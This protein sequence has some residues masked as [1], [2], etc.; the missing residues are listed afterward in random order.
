MTNSASHKKGKKTDNPLFRSYLN[1][2][3]EWDWVLVGRNLFYLSLFFSDI[4]FPDLKEDCLN[5][6]TL[7]S[8]ESYNAVQERLLSDDAAQAFEMPLTYIKADGS[9]YSHFT[10]VKMLAVDGF[11]EMVLMGRASHAK[12]VKT[13]TVE[14]SERY[15][16]LFN[17]IRDAVLVSEVLPD[18]TPGRFI[19]VNDVACKQLGYS[20]EE[21]LRLSLAHIVD[22]KTPR[23]ESFSLMKRLQKEGEMVFKGSHT[24]KTGVK[25]PVEIF[26]KLHLLGDSPVCI[27]IARDLNEYNAQQD[28]LEESRIRFEVFM[29]HLPAI[30]SIRDEDSRFTYVNPSF[31]KHFGEQIVGKTLRDVFPPHVVNA[32]EQSA[33]EVFKYGVTTKEFKMPDRSGHLRTWFMYSFKLPRY[34]SSP[35][36][37]CVGIDISEQK[38]IEA[39][40][41]RA[42]EHAEQMYRLKTSLLTNLSH[43]V[44][45]PMNGIIGFS[46]IMLESTAEPDLQRQASLIFHSAVRLMKT[47]DSMLTLSTLESGTYEYKPQILNLAEVLSPVAAKFTKMLEEKKLNLFLNFQ[48]DITV[49]LDKETVQ[50]C[51]AHLLENAIKFTRKGS[52]EVSLGTASSFNKEYAQIEVSDTGIGIAPAHHY[53]IFEAFQQVSEGYNR[54]FEGIGLGLTITKKTLEIMEGMIKV[55]SEPGKGSTFTML[56]PCM[57]RMA[58]DSERSNL[59]I[60]HEVIPALQGVECPSVLLI[61]DNISNIELVEVYLMHKCQLDYCS[62]VEQAL[63]MASVKQYHV[64]LADINLGPGLNGMELVKRLKEFA[65]YKYVPVIAVTGFVTKGDQARLVEAGFN[66]FIPKPFSRAEMIECLAKYYPSLNKLA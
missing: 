1:S 38:D 57:D 19:E 18:Y 35:L 25:I 9:E 13:E 7:L 66:D 30:A 62:T 45:T 65:A 52:I 3:S 39:E 50:T 59:A 43:E 54:E 12:T 5:E 16:S 64:V 8:D 24:T 4:L 26:A 33:H 40:L 11:K 55:E 61:E 20:R 37:G 63:E 23:A 41:V 29:K 51:F 2:Q 49:F 48:K 58:A 27:S 28:I 6:L 47:L 15:K 36:I 10:R 46:E 42:K 17:N 21:L 31:E 44:R 56:V 34:G 14:T 60:G 53:T 32:Y 22:S